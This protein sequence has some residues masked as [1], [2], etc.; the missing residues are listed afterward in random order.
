MGTCISESGFWTRPRA[1]ESIPTTMALFIKGRGRRTNSKA[2]ERRVGPTEA[3]MWEN[4]PTVISRARVYSHGLTIAGIRENSKKTSF[5]AMASIYGAMEGF[6]TVIGK[7]T[8]CMAQINKQESSHGQTEGNI[9]YYIFLYFHKYKHK[10]KHN[11][12]YNH[13]QI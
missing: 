12:K 5:K 4:T 8:K 9:L 3:N 1:K 13:I 11:D 6:I 7:I 2:K 10:H